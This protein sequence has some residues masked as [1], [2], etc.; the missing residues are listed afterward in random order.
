MHRFFF[1]ILLSLL[2]TLNSIAISF[3]DKNSNMEASNLTSWRVT[4]QGEKS[5]T[6]KGSGKPFTTKWI[7]QGIEID[8][9]SIEG[10]TNQDTKGGL[11]LS[12]AEINGSVKITLRRKRQKGTS[13]TIITTPK[14][15]ISGQKNILTLTSPM[16]LESSTSDGSQSF[17]LSGN[18]AIFQ[19]YPASTKKVEKAPALSSKIKS[20]I[21]AGP[22]QLSFKRMVHGTIYVSKGTCEKLIL[23]E[24]LK[25]IILQGNVSLDSADPNFPG[26]VSANQATLTLNDK[27]E[28][29]DIEF[30]GNPGQ[31]KVKKH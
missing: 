10:T 2:A 24:D 5:F 6:F 26:E 16:H 13:T 7:K 22:I 8:G 11:L 29:K 9:S 23:E 28:I 12:Q 25:K 20:G 21:I 18:D 1:I 3:K 17:Q 15:T 27:L 19:L 30:T 14:A 4:K 31:T